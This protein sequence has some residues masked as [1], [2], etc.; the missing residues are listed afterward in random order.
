MDDVTLTFNPNMFL[1]SLN[2]INLGLEKM[3]K[4]FQSFSTK[5]TEGMKKVK[6]SSIAVA[7]GM[8]LAQ[9]A[10][11]GFR[12]AWAGVPE[13]A[14]TLSIAG[15]IISKNLL[16]PLRQE[17]LPILQ[18]VL[19][20]VR[21]HRAMFVKWG[22]V[23]RNVFIVI[24]RIVLTVINILKKLWEGFLGNVERTFGVT[25]KKMTDLANL[26]IFKISAVI[27][28]LLITLEPVGKILMKIFDILQKTVMA[29]VK[30]LTEGLQDIDVILEDAVSSFK[31]MSDMLGKTLGSSEKLVKVFRTLGIVLG[32]VVG[33]AIRTVI[34]LFDTLV[35]AIVNAVG[36]V[37]Y[38]IAQLRGEDSKAKSIKDQILRDNKE[39]F[40]RLKQRIS[41]QAAAIK[42]AKIN[43]GGAWEDKE[44]PSNKLKGS[45]VS[46]SN[47]VNNTVNQNININNKIDGTKDP[48]KTADEVSRK[49]REQLSRERTKA[50]RAM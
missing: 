5:N 41:D 25:T 23:I 30:G 10:M 44:K 37:R 49:I 45:T 46:N 39:A 27:N 7:K 26:L 34:T 11:A 9:V 47:T 3:D 19:D 50:G 29:F 15:S 48:K 1:E 43:I 40:D 28:Y 18:K 8:V 42:S 14:R 31:M 17:L 2:K 24:K 35:M 6:T 4:N 20:W 16:W 32:T 22:N 21:D 36:W 13:I 33:A 12:K 38:G